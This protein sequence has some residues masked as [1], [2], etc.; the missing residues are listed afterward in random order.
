MDNKDLQKL[1]DSLDEGPLGTRKEWQWDRSIQQKGVFQDQFR[2]S[3]EKRKKA[4]ISNTA[5]MN[6]KLGKAKADK[7]KIKLR[8]QINQYTL[9][10]EFIKTH[11]S[12]FLAQ[13][14]INARSA[15]ISEMINGRQK[16]AHG[17]IWIE[18]DKATPKTIELAVSNAISKRKNRVAQYTKQGKLVKIYDSVTYAINDYGYGI[19]DN[20]SGKTKTSYGYVWKYVS[21][22]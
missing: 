11:E 14:A 12:I 16:S 22:G 20:I 5:H 4:G 6:T 3:I 21:N 18:K 15:G 2:T 10:G 17:F 8:K 7:G 13:K 9:N 1:L 19:R